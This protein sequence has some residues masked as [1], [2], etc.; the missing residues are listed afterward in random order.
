MA[1]GN[2]QK[3]TK[4]RERGNGLYREGKLSEAVKAYEAA[5]KLAPSDPSPLSN[6]SAVYFETGK[7]AECIK[8]AAKALSL[9]KTDAKTEKMREKLLVR[10]AKANLYL[11]NIPEAEK[12]LDQLGPDTDSSG[13]RDLLKGLKVS[14]AFSPHSTSLLEMLFQMP[15]LRPSLVDLPEYFGVGDDEAESQY[16]AELEKSTSG[17]SVLSL[18]FCGVGDARNLFQTL[19]QYGSKKK[20]GPQKL[21]VTMVDKNPAIVARDLIFFSLLKEAATN[22]ATKEVSL[23]TVSYLFCTQIIPSFVWEKLQETINGL[24]GK[25]KEKQQPLDFVHIPVSQVEQ[26]IEV[27]MSWQK[28]PATDWK[29]PQA[30]GVWPAS[31]PAEKDEHYPECQADHQ[32]FDDFA[33]LFP[34]IAVLAN[35]EP[36]LFAL[37]TRYQS[38]DRNVRKFIARYLDNHWRVNVTLI[39][40]KWDALWRQ[41]EDELD[42][43]QNNPRVADWLTQKWSKLDFFDAVASSI[44]SLGGRLTIEMIIGDMMDVLERLRYGLLDR[45][46]QGGDVDNPKLPTSVDWPQ[47]YHIIHMNNIPDYVGGSLTSFLYAG[48]VLKEGVGSSLTSNVQRNPAS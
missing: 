46:K 11:S 28:G 33:V 17:E 6:L 15:R 34:P 29:T 26:Y 8:F 23:M 12:L 36:K 43:G 31:P 22:E 39:D 1:S 37:V 27:L 13:L 44:P 47:T 32:V 42:I 20:E 38:G 35:F 48:P 41:P 14:D 30:R 19:V 45:S 21:H 10:Q 18:M 2:P 25:L 40:V 16:T 7:Y 5:A 24:V 9:N 4:A 3:A